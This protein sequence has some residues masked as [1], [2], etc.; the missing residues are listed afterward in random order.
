MDDLSRE[1]YYVPVLLF[2]FNSQMQPKYNNWN[3]KFCNQVT[4][5]IISHLMT[6]HHWLVKLYKPWKLS[7]KSFSLLCKSSVQNSRLGTQLLKQWKKSQKY[8]FI[9]VKT[10]FL[11][12][13]IDI[14]KYFFFCV[15]SMHHIIIHWLK[16]W[17]QHF[18]LNTFV[19]LQI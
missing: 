17:I 6:V 16:A 5:E 2:L 9:T 18:C 13:L 19:S 1:W 11:V 14:Y 15:A 10:S 8:S 3:G 12:Y 4:P 7:R